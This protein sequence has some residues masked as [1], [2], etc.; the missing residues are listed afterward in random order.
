MISNSGTTEMKITNLATLY[1]WVF[2]VVE[3]LFFVFLPMFYIVE[4]Y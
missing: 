4:Q 3:V 2:V 1:S